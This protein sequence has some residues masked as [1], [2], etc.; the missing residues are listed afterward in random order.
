MNSRI[1]VREILPTISVPT[2]ILHRVGDRDV[3]IEEG[4]YIAER[5]PSARFI[6]LPGDEHVI[7][8]GEVDRL[9]TRSRSS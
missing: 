2:L 5:I 7:A 1:D 6:E 8:A 4:R 3:K 9:A